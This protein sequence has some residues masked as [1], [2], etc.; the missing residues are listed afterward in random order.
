MSYVPLTEHEIGQ[1]F[2]ALGSAGLMKLT[3]E[4]RDKLRNPGKFVHED[5]PPVTLATDEA[6]DE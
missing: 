6:P 4:L 2:A 3:S 1:L 5:V